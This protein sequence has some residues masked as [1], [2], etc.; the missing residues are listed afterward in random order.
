LS[1]AEAGLSGDG[2]EAELGEFSADGDEIDLDEAGIALDD[3]TDLDVSELVIDDDE[4][5]LDEVT[6]DDDDATLD[7]LDIA[8][9]L[10]E[11]NLNLELETGWREAEEKLTRKD[12]LSDNAVHANDDEV[13]AEVDDDDEE[14]MKFT[15][16][17]EPEQSDSSPSVDDGGSV[18]VCISADEDDAEIASLDSRILYFPDG[19]SDKVKAEQFEELVSE[20]KMT[21]QTMRDQ[22]QNLT[23]RQ[24]RQERDT[25]ELH[26]SVAKLSDSS[27]EPARNERKKLS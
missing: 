3:D 12:H 24:Y 19:G 18:A 20:V 27:P 23:E 6:L 26:K 10:S 14:I 5:D 8:A 22:L 16:P 25:H 13:V 1:S 7:N 9:A 17:E 2:I 4:I 21:L 15:I 11:T